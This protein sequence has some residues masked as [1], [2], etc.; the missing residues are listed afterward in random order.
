M[1][2][3][4]KL[5]KLFIICLDLLLS[6]RDRRFVAHIIL[7][8][9]FFLGW[10]V[11][12]QAEGQNT[13]KYEKALRLA[14]DGQHEAALPMLR[15]L[16]E[17]FPEESTYL[18]DY[19]TVL[20][21]MERDSDVLFL[22]SQIDLEI[23]PPYV[24]E[25]FGLSARNVENFPLAIKF[26][27]LAAQREPA[28]LESELGLALSHA[29]N[30]ETEKTIEML[31]RLDK[32]TPG[33]I[34][35]L[36]AFAFVY[37]LRGNPFEELAVHH[38]ILKVD[39]D[40]RESIRRRILIT[41]QL[42]APHL[43]A[44]M[45]KKKTGLLSPEEV[46][47]IIGDQA[48]QLMRWGGFYNP[49]PQGRFQDID[50]AIQL[51]QDQLQR[52]E[53][54]GDVRTEAYRRAR[55]DLVVAFR[56]RERMRDVIVLYEDLS[57]EETTDIPSYVLVPIADAYLYEKRPVIARDLYLEALEKNP[58]DFDISISL[59][60]ALFDAGEYVS[61][62][63]LIDTLT[64]E[65]G[66]NR[67]KLRAESVAIMGYAWSDQLAE[68]QR[69]LEPLVDRAPNN[70]Y[71]HS[72]LGY[73]YLW[74]GWPRRAREEFQLSNLIESEVLGAQIGKV[75][76]ERE[77]NEFRNAEKSFFHLEENHIDNKEVQR[78][79]RGWK[80]H[81][82][83]ELLVDFSDGRSSSSLQEG[84]RDL[85]LDATLYSRPFDYS[86][87]FFAH[88][89][90][91]QSKFPEG[92]GTYRRQGVG[93]QYHVKDLEI[94]GELSGGYSQDAGLGLDLRANWMPDDYWVLG[95]E[96]NTYSNEVPLRGR[97]NEDVDGWSVGLNAD[98]RF[99]ESRT[100]GVGLQRLESS[101]NNRR[102]TYSATVLQRLMTRA[103]YKLS[104]RLGFYGSKNT[105]VNAS[106][107]N[108]S[109]DLSTEVTLVNEW[110][111]FRHYSR[112][113]LHRLGLSV[114]RYRQSG[115]GSKGFWGIN[116]D[117][118]WEINDS[119]NLLYGVGHSSPVYD[120]ISETLTQYTMTLDWRF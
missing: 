86:T 16:T 77:L 2:N 39:P 13:G 63:Q 109:R 62:L 112:S 34:A 88:S 83:R 23:A 59:F 99:H 72:D 41:A 73:I 24:L 107:Y 49:T 48:A 35:I 14:R 93:L 61:A 111:Q 106:Y 29:E 79:G 32:K 56:D 68:A 100:I 38:R 8:G 75:E 37:E 19:I 96:I 116:Y 65:Q 26:Y 27:T 4:E 67:R 45:V 31:Q 5:P 50:A 94:S 46:E 81:N 58:K 28:T 114:G 74:R 21:W 82:M 9:L 85:V 51:L 25:T 18:Y 113:L 95:A 53:A 20:G 7:G 30:G 102:T 118:Q 97:L 40:H 44:E 12:L 15:E 69:R 98:Y 92:T 70:P 6:F 60:Y 71:L 57:A 90:Y 36:E 47:V 22:Q 117:H 1:F 17:Q 84:S 3:I 110:L 55:F 76:V 52:L 33:E 10:P 42:G 80:I 105:L 66:E 43:A 108:P 89:H 103:A 91:R 115:F 11:T 119:L 87:R 120:G 64:A 104:G 101:D 54:R 78:L